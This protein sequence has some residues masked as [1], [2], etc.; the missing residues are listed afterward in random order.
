[1]TEYDVLVYTDYEPDDFLALL[2]V[3]KLFN[4]VAVVVTENN[5]EVRQKKCEDLL[6]FFPEF[7]VFFGKGSTK[8]Y[9]FLKN[10]AAPEVVMRGFDYFET[11]APKI[12]FGIAP[13]RD[14]IAVTEEMPD[15]FKESTVYFYGGFNF[16]LVLDAGVDL[17]KWFTESFKTIVVF[18]TRNSFGDQLNFNK[19]SGP[20][21]PFLESKSDDRKIRR[22]LDLMEAWDNH[23]VNKKIKKI[24]DFQNKHSE[25]ASFKIPEQSFEL[26]ECMKSNTDMYESNNDWLF[27]IRSVDV[28][29]ALGMGGHQTVAA[30]PVAVIMYDEPLDSSRMMPA[31]F[32]FPKPGKFEYQRVEKSNFYVF[33]PEGLE[34]QHAAHDEV[35]AKIVEILK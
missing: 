31:L 14:M 12:V 35:E 28:V 22:L 21:I 30:D 4:N 9:N 11:K 15:Y 2:I 8:E 16:A 20:L 7:A 19:N 33:K 6:F 23:I 26:R 34:A 5:S 17:T 13:P 27:M 3:R 29:V 10:P 1:M 18:E 24:G 32:T 25:L